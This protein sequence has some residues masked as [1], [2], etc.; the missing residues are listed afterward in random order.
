MRNLFPN[1]VTRNLSLP[2][3]KINI[4]DQNETFSGDFQILV[5]LDN[6]QIHDLIDSKNIYYSLEISSNN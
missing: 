3:T 6:T 1:K 4:C 2:T 5:I